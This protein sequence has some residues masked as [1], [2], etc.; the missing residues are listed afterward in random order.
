MRRMSQVRGPR[1]QGGP[2]VLPASSAANIARSTLHASMRR[3]LIAAVVAVATLAG[4]TVAL[5]T[6][7]LERTLDVGTVRLSIDP[8]HEGALDLYVPLVD[9]GVRFP[10]VRLPARVEVDV[11]AVDRNA[12]VQLAEA[13]QLNVAAVRNQARDALAHYLRLA[14]LVS[15]LAGLAFGLLVALA[16]RG[17]PGPRL[18]FTLGVAGATAIA[19]GVALAVLLPPRSNVDAPEYYA[20]G[21][22]VPTALRAL[23]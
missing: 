11:R 19:G 5:A 4:A 16:V 21:P 14:I 2:R 22:E 8:G 18:R 7:T 10:V 15:V 20:N 3:V 23:Q 12:V 6:F 1:R 17:G 13:G 9:W